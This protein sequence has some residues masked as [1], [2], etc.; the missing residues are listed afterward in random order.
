MGGRFCFA[1]AAARLYNPRFRA[2]LPF[3]PTHFPTLEFQPQRRPLSAAPPRLQTE[4]PSPSAPRPAAFLRSLCPLRP[5]PS[6][7]RSATE[8]LVLYTGGSIGFWRGDIKLL[9]EDIEALKP[10]LFAGVPRVYDR[11]YAGVV[12]KVRRLQ[13]LG[14]V[15]RVAFSN[16][17]ILFYL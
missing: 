14:L 12:A 13:C 7:R 8:E 4:T 17:F 16:N 1:A 10:T 15:S 9:V 6:T 5:R 11:I 2:A 3:I